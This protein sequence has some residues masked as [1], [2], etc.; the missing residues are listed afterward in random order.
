M[1]CLLFALLITSAAQ[2][3]A[4]EVLYATDDDLR[5][6]SEVYA[7][8][9]AKEVR[10]QWLLL[11]SQ[12]QDVEFTGS[13]V[14]SVQVTADGKAKTTKVIKQDGDF[15]RLEQLT[16]KAVQQAQLKPVPQM[17]VK[18][19]AVR[20]MPLPSFQVSVPF[21]I[22]QAQAAIP[23]FGLYV[24]HFFVIIFFFFS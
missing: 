3:G 12:K 23:L 21:E 1:R 22:V 19:L 24:V 18:G 16:L 2:M 20:Q 15:A 14:M 10:R 5:A 7:E 17:L 13:L 11:R 6:A 8:A 4:Q 9:A